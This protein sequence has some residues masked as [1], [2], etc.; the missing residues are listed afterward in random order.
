M[1]DLQKEQS[2]ISHLLVASEIIPCHVNSDIM[3]M[4]HS[5]EERI[6]V[7]VKRKIGDRVRS[8][9]NRAQHA[10]LMQLYQSKKL[11]F[12]E[13]GGLFCLFSRGMIYLPLSK[14][15]VHRYS[16]GLVYKNNSPFDSCMRTRFK[17]SRYFYL[18]ILTLLVSTFILS[19]SVSSSTCVLIFNVTNSI[20]RPC[21]FSQLP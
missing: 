21:C 16:R 18:N 19:E 20:F 7:W 5:N 10:A 4:I 17:I 6:S 11:L 14:L 13:N 2:R 8:I 9:K 15:S 3:Y 1:L 12:I